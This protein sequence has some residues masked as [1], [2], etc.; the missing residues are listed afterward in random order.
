MGSQNITTSPA[1]ELEVPPH[2]DGIYGTPKT[3]AEYREL[4]A[5]IEP[6]LSP[7][8]Q[9]HLTKLDHGIM[10]TLTTNHVL[11]NQVA[12]GPGRPGDR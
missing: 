2:R 4:L 7:H 8:S 11:Q 6:K 10:E 12:K 1:P 9:R 5:R 3:I